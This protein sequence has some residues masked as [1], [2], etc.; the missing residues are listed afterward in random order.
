MNRQFWGIYASFIEQFIDFKRQLG[1]KYDTEEVIYSI[2]DRFTLER[3]ETI[4]G[5]T[6]DLADA[7]K[8]LKPNESD[9]YRFHRVVCLN[10]LSSFLIR[11]GI[12][13]Y[14]SQLPRL[15]STFTPYIFSR[16]ELS[17]IFKACDEISTKKKS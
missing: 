8:M 16:H 5:I 6:K 17:D 10:Q 11:M 2:F 15:K 1:F 3:D 13:S 4:V 7:W 9:S 12:R 14:I